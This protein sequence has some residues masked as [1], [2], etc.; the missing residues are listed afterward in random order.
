[1]FSVTGLAAR[2][3]QAVAM[4]M[5]KRIE[6][7]VKFHF[8]SLSMWPPQTPLSA[9]HSLTS[10]PSYNA[11]SQLCLFPESLP[12]LPRLSHVISVLVPLEHLL[13]FCD[14]SSSSTE[15][16]L[17]C[18]PGKPRQETRSLLLTLLPQ[19]RAQAQQMV[20]IKNNHR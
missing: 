20:Q 13:H 3:P 10:N 16:D 17:I 8:F 19:H 11:Q 15:I 9:P 14:G 6:S 7:S 5:G 1:M 2:S 12:C 4:E 18:F